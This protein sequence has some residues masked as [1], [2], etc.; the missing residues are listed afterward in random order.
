MKTSVTPKLNST[1]YVPVCLRTVPN[2]LD[3]GRD[4]LKK[5]T[6]SL[7]R[8]QLVEADRFVSKVFL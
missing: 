8:V 6:M 4:P 7:A 1:L 5:I 2:N 3:L